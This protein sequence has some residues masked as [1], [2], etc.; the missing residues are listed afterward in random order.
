MAPTKTLGALLALLVV[1]TGAAAA[2]PG[3]APVDAPD[4][5]DNQ[6]A[7]AEAEQAAAQAQDDEAAADDEREA[8]GPDA[9]SDAAGERGPP[10]DMPGAAPDF[11]S[12][13][14]QT[15]NDYLSGAVDDLGSAISE[16]TPGE[17]GGDDGMDG[18]NASEMPDGAGEE[19]AQP[20]GTPA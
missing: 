10:A 2:M 6:T 3:N 17:T 5:A 11:V 4:R 19:T 9:A 15:I 14:H 16:V 7:D 18:E 1:A 20:D 12:E 13:L 8:G